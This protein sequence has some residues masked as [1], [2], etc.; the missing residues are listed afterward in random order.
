MPEPVAATAAQLPARGTLLGFD[1]GLARI[2]V[3]CAEL[4]TGHSTP[5]TTIAA[6]ASDVRFKAIGALIAEWRPVALVVG[7]PF[8]L[9]GS[10]HELTLR[11]RRF[12][13]QLHGRFSLP[14]F[15]ADE[16]LSSHAAETAL[17]EAGLTGWQARKPVLD[18]AAAAIILQTF[19]DTCRHAQT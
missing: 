4:E 1:F 7:I 3:A 5:L 11:C 18:A 10:E 17:T 19:V 14:V 9:D 13:N 8:R 12:A 6:E 15:G 16:R 2:G